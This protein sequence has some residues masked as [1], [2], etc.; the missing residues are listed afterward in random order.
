MRQVTIERFTGL[1]SAHEPPCIS[2][3][4]PT[5]RNHPDDQQDPIRFRNLIRE[6]ERL[7]GERYPSRLTRPILDRLEALGRDTAF[8]KYRTEGLAVFASPDT[9]ELFE[10][11]RTVP[12]RIIVADSFHIKPLIRI[13]QSSDRYQ[14]LCLNR[15]EARLYEG[16][17]DAL[18]PVDLIDTPAT[19]NEVIG[20]LVQPPEPVVGMYGVKAG[21]SGKTFHGYGSQNDPNEINRER[22]FRLV[23]RDIL[24][25]HSRPSGL[26]LMLAALPESQE[27]FRKFSR[28]PFLLPVGIETNPDTLSVEQLREEAWNQILP[29]YLARLDELKEKFSAAHVRHLAS[30]DLSDVARAVVAGRVETLLVEADRVIPGTLDRTTGAIELDGK[31]SVHVDDLLD[32]VAELT[33][34]KGGEVIIVPAERMPTTSGL[35]AIYRF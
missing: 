6:V 12:E 17:R 34:T 2:I 31:Q 20:E 30:P 27:A 14:V 24:E 16:N 19:I 9:F 23:D 7:L 15:R 8:W 1:L 18:D 22:F 29:F 5:H 35:A 25:N 21:P 13:L 4:Q 32:D 28:N 11:Q 33:L 3:Y 10:L 26:P